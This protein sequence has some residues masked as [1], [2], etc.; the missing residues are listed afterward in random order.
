MKKK[1]IFVLCTIL[2]LVTGCGKVPVLK[3]G[4]EVFAQIDG[5]NISA[6]DIYNEL[7]DKYGKDVMIDIIDK[8]LLEKKYKD[9]DEIKDYVDSQISVFIQQYG[10]DGFKNALEQANM[11][12][13][14]LRDQIALDYRRTKAA[15]DYV[16]DTIKD[17]EINKY[18][19]NDIRGDIKASHI[20]I[21]PDVSD[22]ATDEE[23]EKAEKEAKKKA[24]EIITKL[25]NGE[26]FADLAKEYSS[27]EGTAKNGGDLGYF[28]KG[29][30]VDEFENAVV[31]LKKDEY[32]KEPVKSSYGYHI[33]LKTGE[34]SK[35]KLKNV[36]DEIID[37]LVTE[38][39]QNDR[40]LQYKALYEVRKKAGLEIHDDSVKSKY[41]KYMDSLMKSQN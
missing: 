38:K 25:N 32:T 40:T 23:K 15:K 6:N 12:E 21:K 11:T 37:S 7:K 20:L 26:K 27:D 18:Y 3:N 41:E 30:M 4:E 8:I 19:E 28:P 31:K 33:I 22:D 1:V 9:S 14:D 17:D 16:A 36:K 13:S 10:E 24:E 5:K 29:Q 39:M 35:P 2:L 34:K